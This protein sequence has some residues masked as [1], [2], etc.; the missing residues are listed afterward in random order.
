MHIR[1]ERT[2]FF[3]LSRSF[4]DIL[5]DFLYN[6]PLTKTL[7]WWSTFRDNVHSRRR[8]I[9]PPDNSGDKDKT[10]TGGK[11]YD[12]YM[13]AEEIAVITRKAVGTVVKV[14][15]R[16]MLERIVPPGD[17][18]QRFSPQDSQKIIDDI[19]QSGKNRGKTTP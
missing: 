19:N 1:G 7:E 9:M 8:H 16:L 3:L 13:T 4:L 18:R 2:L 17:T 10:G 5:D 11:S 6:G 14:A 15:N 12:G